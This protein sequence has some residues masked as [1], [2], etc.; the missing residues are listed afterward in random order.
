VS[1]ANI[2]NPSASDTLNPNY[3]YRETLGDVIAEAQ[4]RSGKPFARLL[5]SRGRVFELMWSERL[6]ADAAKL[7]QWHQQYEQGFFTLADWEMGRYYS[8]RFAGRPAIAPAGNNNWN[9]SAQFVELPGLPMFAYPTNWNRD[10][11]FIEE[12]DDFGSPNVKLTG[13]WTQSVN[14][15]HH[16][17]KA[18]FSATTNN[19]AEWLYFGYGFRLWAAKD[20]NLGIVAVSIDGGAETNVDLYAASLQ[21]SAVVHTNANQNLG[22]HRVKLRVTG[23][24]NAS[25]SAFTVY[26]DAIEVMR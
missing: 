18:Y 21:A 20:A 5:R 9:A 25:S 2:L 22:F 12:I 4:M 6:I 15:A 23:T 10:A 17:G 16:G 14:A 13:A 11:I 3:G 24:K 7:R 8:G 1:E 19:A 26:A